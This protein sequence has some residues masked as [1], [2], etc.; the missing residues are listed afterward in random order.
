VIFKMIFCLIFFTLFIKRLRNVDCKYWLLLSQS[1]NHRID[2]FSMSYLA[3]SN[4]S[5]LREVHVFSC[6]NAMK[7]VCENSG[8]QSPKFC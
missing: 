7:I 1:L 8:E 4:M 2:L 6:Q 5:R 3:R